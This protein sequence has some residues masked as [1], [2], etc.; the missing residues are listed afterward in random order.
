MEEIPV[1]SAEAMHQQLRVLREGADDNWIIRLH[2]AISWLERAEAI[3]PASAEAEFLFLWIAL[4]SLYGSWSKATSFPMADSG[5]R[6]HF[7]KDVFTWDP[8]PF[9]AFVEQNRKHIHLLIAC[10]HLTMRFWSTPEDPAAG[11]VAAK[12]AEMLDWEIG[13]GHV[14]WVLERLTDRIYVLRSQVVHGA[15]TAGSYVNRQVFTEA[16]YLLQRLVPLCVQ[17][18]LTKGREKKWPEICYPP[19]GD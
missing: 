14:G 8:D 15:S 7:I 17:V 10:K 9:R 1:M 12:D 4:S 18:A 13:R 2:R 16:H 6:P 5:T 19:T 11:S 3:A